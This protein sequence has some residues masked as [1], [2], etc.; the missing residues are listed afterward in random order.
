II[1]DLKIDILL[2]DFSLKEVY[3]TIETTQIYYFNCTESIQNDVELINYQD[4]I[5]SED[6]LIQEDYSIVFSSG[7]SQ[8]IKYINRTFHEI[9]KDKKSL[10][11]K[12]KFYWSYRGSTWYIIKK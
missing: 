8:H 4:Q 11:E 3:G 7:T 10:L 6:N 2:V 9:K 5:I 1:K 12:F